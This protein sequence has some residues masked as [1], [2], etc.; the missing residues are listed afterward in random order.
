MRTRHAGKPCPKPD[1]IP[2]P[3]TPIAQGA[4][5]L[6]AAVRDA[7]VLLLQQAARGRDAGAV[8]RGVVGAGA[9]QRQQAASERLSVHCAGQSDIL[10]RSAGE[11][12]W[13]TPTKMGAAGQVVSRSS[14]ASSRHIL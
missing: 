10:E 6:Q 5:R 12:S 13:R 11:F 7:V 2:K 14:T 9:L 3:A 4:A 8:H 1:P